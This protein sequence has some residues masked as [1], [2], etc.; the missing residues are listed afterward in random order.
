MISEVCRTPGPLGP[1]LSSRPRPEGLKS[2]YHA[3]EGKKAL[4]VALAGQAIISKRDRSYMCQSDDPGDH[5]PIWR[6]EAAG[7][8]DPGWGCDI[9]AATRAL[10][11]SS[12]RPSR[13][14]GVHAFSE[15]FSLP[16]QLI[17]QCPYFGR[18]IRTV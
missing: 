1:S 8:S 13:T 17:R 6:T 5:F 9:T 11:A 15:S 12:C 10:R 2:T 4:P 3:C 7:A 18:K 16:L 14:M